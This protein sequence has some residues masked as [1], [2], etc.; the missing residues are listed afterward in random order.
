MTTLANKYCFSHNVETTVYYDLTWQQEVLR[1]NEIHCT[2]SWHWDWFKDRSEEE[3][4]N[5]FTKINN[6]SNSFIYLYFSSN[7]EV[8][9]TKSISLLII[10][11]HQHFFII[12]LTFWSFSELDEDVIPPHYLRDDLQDTWVTVLIYL[13]CILRLFMKTN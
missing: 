8:V 12:L 5:V 4:R 2:N 6:S 7:P 1:I 3:Y 9:L 11:S 10:R 13:F